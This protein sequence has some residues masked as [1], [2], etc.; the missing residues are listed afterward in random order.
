MIWKIDPKAHRR[1]M[2]RALQWSVTDFRQLE[3]SQLSRFALPLLTETSRAKLQL[4]LS[5]DLCNRT[6]WS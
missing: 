5:N 1:P 6:R 2:C 3:R 4:K